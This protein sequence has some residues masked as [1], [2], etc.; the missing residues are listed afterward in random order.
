MSPHQADLVNAAKAEDT[1]DLLSHIAWTDVIK[2]KLD[3]HV[4][5]LS[6]LLVAEALGAPLAK[7]QTRERIAGMCYGVQ[8]ISRVFEQVLRDGTSAVQNLSHEGISL[9]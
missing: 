2:P 3:E 7:G 6:A 8:Y 5:K 1:Q 4:S 9:G